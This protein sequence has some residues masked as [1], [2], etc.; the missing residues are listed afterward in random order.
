MGW[1]S[2]KTY[3]LSTPKHSIVHFRKLKTLSAS[4]F[5]PLAMHCCTNYW[6]P[7]SYFE[8]S[9]RTHKQ[10]LSQ[11]AHNKKEMSVTHISSHTT[12]SKMV[13]TCHLYSAV[14][15]NKAYQGAQ[16]QILGLLDFYLLEKC[17][18][19]WSWGVLLWILLFRHSYVLTGKG[20]AIW[21]SKVTALTFSF[22]VP[23]NNCFHS[24]KY[25]MQSG[26]ASL[27]SEEL[28]LHLAKSTKH[29]KGKRKNIILQICHPPFSTV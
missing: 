10:N 9:S 22:S 13:A 7:K 18:K 16:E 20:I 25:I 24:N 1:Q 23:I 28:D 5:L 15:A 21:A 11:S 3:H 4:I 17:H 12:E 29:K 8:T 26:R 2:F 14:W 19:H 6:Q 27:W